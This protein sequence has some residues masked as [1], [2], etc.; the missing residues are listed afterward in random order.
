MME[1]VILGAEKLQTNLSP[2]E[3]IKTAAHYVGAS[4][5]KADCEL[6]GYITLYS[7]TQ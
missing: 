1:G 5:Q 2:H 3:S 6:L 7:V 4:L